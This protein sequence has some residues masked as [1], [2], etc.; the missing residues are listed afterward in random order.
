[1]QLGADGVPPLP[2]VAPFTVCV[3]EL[4]DLIRDFIL[5]R[6]VRGR[7]RATP[8]LCCVAEEQITTRVS[9]TAMASHNMVTVVLGLQAG[10]HTRAV[11]VSLPVPGC[12]AAAAHTYLLQ[13]DV[14]A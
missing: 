4:L 12:L 5:E 3:P 13:P 1:M 10:S 6:W 8:W 14:P 11:P 7:E 9:A 2:Y